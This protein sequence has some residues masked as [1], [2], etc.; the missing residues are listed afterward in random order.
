MASNWRFISFWNIW[1]V[2]LRKHV[3]MC[4][5]K[6]SKHAEFYCMRHLFL[7]VHFPRWNTPPHP[8]HTVNPLRSH[9]HWGS[10]AGETVSLRAVMWLE[11]VGQCRFYLSCHGQIISLLYKWDVI[12]S[13]NRW[14][15][16][17]ID[18][19]ILVLLQCSLTH[20]RFIN[21]KL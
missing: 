2:T 13:V 1:A 21:A 19:G 10:P 18:A 9:T 15:I 4:R 14:S 8:L 3:L 17:V 6:N 20:V 12:F 7:H 16:K 5:Y 11:D